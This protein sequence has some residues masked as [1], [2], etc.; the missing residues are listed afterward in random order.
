MPVGCIVIIFL[1]LTDRP[2]FLGICSFQSLLLIGRKRN[3]TLA[4]S[5]SQLE[6]GP[7]DFCDS[8]TVLNT[9][10]D[11]TDRVVLKLEDV[12]MVLEISW[13]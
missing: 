12:R 4:N 9:T 5:R 11:W 1:A 3:I 13:D 6:N 7:Y 8:K 10:I 2:V